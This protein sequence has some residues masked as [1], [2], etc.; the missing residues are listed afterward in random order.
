MGISVMRT[1]TAS[2]MALLIAGGTVF[3]GTSAIDF[4]L[5][6]PVGSWV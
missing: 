4:A 3:V 5:K 6:G 1:P 2:R